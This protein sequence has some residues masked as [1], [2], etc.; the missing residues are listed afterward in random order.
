ME[1]LYNASAGVLLVR[2][3]LLGHEKKVVTYRMV[4]PHKVDKLVSES[5]GLEVLLLLGDLWVPRVFQCQ[6]QVPIPQ[7]ERWESRVVVH[8]ATRDSV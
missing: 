2:L 8:L 5:V 6:G 4:V 7:I 1:A 3:E